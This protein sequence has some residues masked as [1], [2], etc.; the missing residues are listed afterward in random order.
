[1]GEIAE[2]F[3]DLTVQ[4]PRIAEWVQKSLENS[5][6]DETEFKATK[7]KELERSKELITGKLDRLYEDRLADIISLN[8]YKE[9]AEALTKEREHI[10]TEIRKTSEGADIQANLAIDIFRVS[11]EAKERFARK[12]PEEKRRLLKLLCE[13]I[14][15]A[16]RKVTTKYHK[17]FE[18]L[19]KAVVSTNSSNKSKSKEIENGMLEPVNFGSIMQ[20]T[21][22]LE[23]VSAI[24]RSRRDSNP[25]PPP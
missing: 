15:I 7:V 22:S 9:K 13:R 23:P 8:F 3:G 16:D 21:G 14:E 5:H 11:Q 18:L 20:K 4:N 1:M 2:K 6:K 24:W 10:E 19:E 17:A 25:R 12:A